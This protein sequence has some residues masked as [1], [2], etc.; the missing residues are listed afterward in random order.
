MQNEEEER[1][2]GGQ[3]TFRSHESPWLGFPSSQGLETNKFVKNR[4]FPARHKHAESKG[5]PMGFLESRGKKRKVMAFLKTSGDTRHTLLFALW[6]LQGDSGGKSSHLCLKST[7]TLLIL[8]SSHSGSPLVLS[9]VSTMPRLPRPSKY[10]GTEGHTH[11][12]S[13]SLHPRPLSAVHMHGILLMDSCPVSG[14]RG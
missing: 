8:P 3:E 7:F 1:P 10:A 11:I 12:R 6:Q 9:D 14:D 13:L 4:H 2:S 5:A